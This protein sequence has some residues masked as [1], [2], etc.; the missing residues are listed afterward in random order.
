MNTTY[1]KIGIKKSSQTAKNLLRGNL[2]QKT[3]QGSLLPCRQNY[4]ILYYLT[5]AVADIF[6][7][8]SI[9]PDLGKV[10]GSIIE[11][12]LCILKRI[13]TFANADYR[14]A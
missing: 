11:N 8:E 7:S 9:N 5:N 14:P 6:L 2:E 1:Y 3:R 4:S 12:D 10:S 13:V